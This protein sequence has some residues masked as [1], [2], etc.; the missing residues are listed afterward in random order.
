LFALDLEAVKHMFRFFDS[1]RP[2]RVAFEITKA[3]FM[4]TPN[5]LV[6]DDLPKGDEQSAP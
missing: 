6:E 5:A 4:L 1:L 3:L 2:M